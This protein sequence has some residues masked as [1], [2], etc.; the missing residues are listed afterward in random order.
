MAKRVR[1][2]AEDEAEEDVVAP[3]PADAAGTTQPC[4][5]TRASC[6]C[7]DGTTL[8]A[9]PARHPVLCYECRRDAH[10]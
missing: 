2:R 6:D 9:H 5:C 10:D 1:V 4:S 7:S 3:P 8:V